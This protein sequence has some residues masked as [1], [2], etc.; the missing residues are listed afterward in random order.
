MHAPTDTLFSLEKT[1]KKKKVCSFLIRQMYAGNNYEKG[2]TQSF[3]VWKSPQ[4]KNKM[5][6]IIK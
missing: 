5:Q 4:I 6:T 2:A 3:M 1:N